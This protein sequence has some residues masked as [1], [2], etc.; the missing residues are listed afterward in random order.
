MSGSVDFCKKHF[1]ASSP[2][3]PSQKKEAPTEGKIVPEI[4]ALMYQGK[5]LG[6]LYRELSP[7]KRKS[8]DVIDV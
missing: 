2:S 7:I 4:T 5:I 6:T 8:A 3:L 1:R